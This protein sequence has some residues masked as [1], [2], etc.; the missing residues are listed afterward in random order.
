MP[1]TELSLQPLT[2]LGRDSV[3]TLRSRQH[4]HTHTLTQTRAHHGQALMLAS[5]EL[6]AKDLGYLTKHMH[7]TVSREGCGAGL[8]G[9]ISQ[10]SAVDESM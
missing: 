1:V 9:Q 5:Y 10:V 4:T 8:T 3:L 6:N 7:P 2:E